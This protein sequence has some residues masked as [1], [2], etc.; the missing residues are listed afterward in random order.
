M[1]ADGRPTS[2][3]PQSTSSSIGSGS[4]SG[5]KHRKHKTKAKAPHQAFV[6]QEKAEAPIVGK[7]G[8]LQ[9]KL[10]ETP[11]DALHL[12]IATDIVEEKRSEPDEKDEKKG[13]TD[14][15][16]QGTSKME[17]L[18][19]DLDN[20]PRHN[21]PTAETPAGS[22]ESIAIKV[23]PV[24]D[25]GSVETVS[26]RAFSLTRSPMVQNNTSRHE[27]LTSG[28]LALSRVVSEQMAGDPTA[29][30]RHLLGSEANHEDS[31]RSCLHSHC[32][33]PGQPP[34][35][36]RERPVWCFRVWLLP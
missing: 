5:K 24:A 14:T 30:C 36:R 25:P 8:N 2:S 12:R 9:A 10:A 6:D 3:T 34:R 16:D 4:S 20:S 27:G 7:P 15:E 23:Q 32:V 29:R 11:R 26:T 28:R 21:Q 31:P 35:A 22:T 33:H 18:Q 1:S 17:M 13:L 19:V